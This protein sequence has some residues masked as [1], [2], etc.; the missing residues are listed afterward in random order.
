MI[1]EILSLS[2]LLKIGRSRENYWKS[3]L[4]LSS[5]KNW[6]FKVSMESNCASSSVRINIIIKFS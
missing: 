1:G 6:K 5:W 2:L 3:R 4:N